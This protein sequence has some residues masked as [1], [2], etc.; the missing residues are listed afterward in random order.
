MVALWLTS[1]VWLLIII[2]FFNG[3]GS[4]ALN[5]M[6]FRL[7]HSTTEVSKR[8]S[9]THKHDAQAVYKKE[10]FITKWVSSSRTE[11]AHLVLHTMKNHNEKDLWIS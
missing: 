7:V 9:I 10:V 3:K 6:L 11:Y 2:F 8:T 1:Y 4:L 5:L